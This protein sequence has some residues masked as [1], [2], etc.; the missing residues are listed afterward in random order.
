MTKLQAET[1]QTSLNMPK[2]IICLTLQVIV[3][4]FE[5]TFSMYP[6]CCYQHYFAVPE[7]RRRLVLYILQQIRDRYTVFIND[8]QASFNYPNVSLSFEQYLHIKEVA[9]QGICHLFPEICTWN[10][11]SMEQP[12]GKSVDAEVELNKKTSDIDS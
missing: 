12:R 10:S 1:H 5:S 2:K 8:S 9:R 6:Y 7:F 4:A 3:E 11:F